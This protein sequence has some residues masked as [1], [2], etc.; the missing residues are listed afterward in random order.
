MAG[1]KELSFL[2]KLPAFLAKEWEALADSTLSLTSSLGEVSVN[3]VVQQPQVTFL[4]CESLVTSSLTVQS[5]HW[6]HESGK[7]FSKPCQLIKSE[8]FNSLKSE[9]F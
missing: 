4:E 6:Q 5:V 8:I 3:L 7:I 1:K 9:T 2:W